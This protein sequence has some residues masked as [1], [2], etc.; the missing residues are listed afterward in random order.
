MNEGRLSMLHRLLLA[1]T[2][3]ALALG[4]GCHETSSGP[5]QAFDP[6]ATAHRPTQAPYARPPSPWPSATTPSALD[7]RSQAQLPVAACTAADGTWRCA[8]PKPKTFAAS[9]GAQPILPASWT[10][11]HWV[12]DASNASGT[13]SD[14][15]DCLTT[16]TPCLTFQEISVHRWGC[17]GNPFACPRLAQATTI[18]QLSSSTSTTDLIYLYPAIE[19]GAYLSFFG[20]LGAAQQVCTGAITVTASKVRTKGASSLLTVTLPVGCSSA[21]ANETVVNTSHPSVAYLNTNTSGTTWTMSQPLA[22]VS[23]PWSGT[24]PPEV[25]TW[26]TSDTVTVYAPV[27][28]PI[29]AVGDVVQLAG[30][31]ISG[32]YVSDVRVK[33]ASTSVFQVGPNVTINEV[34]SSSYIYLNVNQVT[35]TFISSVGE[36]GVQSAAWSDSV[37]PPTWKGGILQNNSQNQFGVALEGGVIWKGFGYDANA[38]INEV[39]VSS[40]ATL[41]ASGISFGGTYP[42]Q[43]TNFIWGPGTFVVNQGSSFFLNH[44]TAAPCLLV[45]TT[46][47]NFFSTGCSTS[48]VSGSVTNCNITVDGAHIDAA[49]GTAGGGGMLWTPSGAN[50]VTLNSPF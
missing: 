27:L 8:S 31:P 15:N 34:R 30:T 23:V 29:V 12:Y 6:P 44:T 7:T 32:V 21:A 42:G 9:S 14:S 28:S 25:D 19:Q 5:E 16:S 20:P 36:N 35:N 41:V 37:G 13:A 39:Y 22:R 48:N 18:E 38:Q 17:L 33:H 47:L 11:P 4:G 40:G 46:Q 3:A 24:D 50:F 45:S 49:F 1:M 26:A 2:I 10:V 43:A